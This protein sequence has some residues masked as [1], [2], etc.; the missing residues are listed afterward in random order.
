MGIED[1]IKSLTKDDIKHLFWYTSRLIVFAILLIT[2]G[3][4]LSYKQAINNANDFIYDN[5]YD[6]FG[7]KYGETI[8]I[9]KSYTG[10]I[11]PI[12]LE[13]ENGTNK[14]S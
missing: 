12:I 8:Y 3:Y 14:Y 9:N 11:S 6:E 1:D 7:H 5:C 4:Q 2:L 13:V 10:F